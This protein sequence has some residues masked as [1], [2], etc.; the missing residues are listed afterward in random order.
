MTP[1]S[2]VTNYKVQ[3]ATFQTAV[4]DLRKGSKKDGRILHKRFCSTYVQL[5]RLQSFKS[6]HLLE[7]IG[8]EDI[9]NKPHPKLEEATEKLD[10]LSDGTLNCWTNFFHARRLN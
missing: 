6:V 2:A 1:G 4:L 3:G 10:E 7:K 9:N 5:S 8:L